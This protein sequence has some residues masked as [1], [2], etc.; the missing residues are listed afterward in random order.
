M[1]DC[2][3]LSKIPSS[4]YYLFHLPVK[5]LEVPLV[6]KQLSITDCKILVENVK[7]KVND[8]KNRVLSY[9]GRL[10]LIASVLASMQVY[11][12]S[13]FLLPKAVI[14]DINKILRGFLW[15]QG[16]LVKGIA[17]V[18]WDVICTPKDQ[19]GLGIKNLQKWNEVLLVKHLWNLA[20]KKD[21]LWVK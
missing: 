2:L 16:D 5:Y 14:N 13:V 17:K 18:A 3:Q 4:K 10:Q 15:N 19:G 6:T 9:A 11:W 7:S 8:W 12:T 20:A 21:S 1:V